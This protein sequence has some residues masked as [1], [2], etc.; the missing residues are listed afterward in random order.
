[1]RLFEHGTLSRRAFL[2]AGG[3][4]VVMAAVPAGLRASLAR[5]AAGAGPYPA[6]DPTSLATWLTVAA[7]G[8]VT[9]RSGHV[10]LGHGVQTGLAQIVAEELDV[11]FARVT[12]VLG[13]SHETPDQGVTAGSTSIR[14]AGAQLRQI[15]AEGRAAL[16]ALASERLGVPAT[17]LAVRDGVVSDGSRRVAYGELVKG[18]VLSAVAPITVTGYG[19]FRMSVAGTA[20]PKDPSQYSTVGRRIARVDVHDK[21]TGR[22]TYVHDVRVPG[23]LHARV[24][25]PKGIGSTLVSVDRVPAGMPGVRVIQR[26]NLV[27]VLADREWDAIKAA[28][29]IQVTWSDWSKLPPSARRARRAARAPRP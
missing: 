25:H 21:V 1:M 24:I 3:A 10:E 7:D 20:R 26:K 14:V 4:L 19:G 6:L 22:A 5:A 16:L 9:A 2:G 11:P 12:M 13:N 23:M 17:R 29:Q 18:R 28:G 27:A 8:G 15:A